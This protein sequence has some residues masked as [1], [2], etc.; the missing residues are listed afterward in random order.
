MRVFGKQFLL[1]VGFIE[2]PFLKVFLRTHKKLLHFTVFYCFLEILYISVSIGME[3]ICSHDYWNL[4]NKHKT[5]H[6][7]IWLSKQRMSVILKI[8]A[9]ILGPI[10]MSWN[11][12]QENIKKLNLFSLPL[13]KT[14]LPLESKQRRPNAPGYDQWQKHVYGNLTAFRN[15]W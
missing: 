9:F 4:E 11:K 14:H 10:Q 2:S 12:W 1:M 7:N 5:H 15:V 6:V 13:N 8:F 3:Q